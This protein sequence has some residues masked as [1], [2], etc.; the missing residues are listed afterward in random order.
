M[1]SEYGSDVAY[2]TSEIGTSSLGRDNSS[3]IGLDDPSLEDELSSPIDKFV[4]YGMSNIDEGLSMGHAILEQLESLPKHK[5]NARD[6][7]SNLDRYVNNG[8][9]S[10][11]SPH[12]TDNLEVLSEAESGTMVHHVRKLSNESIGSDKSSQRGNELSNSAY[13]HSNGYR[14]PDFRSRAEVSTTVGDSDYQLPDNVQLVVPLDQRQKMN[15][16]LTTMQRRLMTAKTDMEDLISRLNQ[17]IAVKDYLGT[18]VFKSF[19]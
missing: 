16:L 2:E 9:S 8:S 1:T 15:R 6:Y 4:K 11:T 19:T 18:K 3:E 10:K 5:V 14:T 12:K 7:H 17:E 13:P